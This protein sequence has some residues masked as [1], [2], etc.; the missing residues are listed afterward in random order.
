MLQPCSFT[1]LLHCCCLLRWW[2]PV[3]TLL[4]LPL[5]PPGV[6]S[7]GSASGRGLPPPPSLHLPIPPP[8]MPLPTQATSRP[9]RP[10]KRRPWLAARCTLAT[11]SSGSA[12]RAQTSWP[13]GAARPPG[14]P[15]QAST[16]PDRRPGRLVRRSSG[17]SMEII[18]SKS[19]GGHFYAT[20]TVLFET[21]LFGGRACQDTFHKSCLL[22][23]I[24]VCLCYRVLLPC[25]VAVCLCLP[26]LYSSD[27]SARAAWPGRAAR[28]AWPKRSVSPSPWLCAC[29]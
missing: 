2:L 18:P 1:L 7:I 6:A 29:T 20:Q 19:G 26:P 24:T 14:K 21:V 4:F 23:F 3:S 13:S 16:F 15:T 10:G 22:F 25:A 17:A 27:G 9:A 11:P 5:R 12:G 28:D 8:L